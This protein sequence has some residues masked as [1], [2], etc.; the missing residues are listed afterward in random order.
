MIVTV[1]RGFSDDPEDLSIYTGQK[2]SH[3]AKIG[4]KILV[5][6]RNGL[7]LVSKL[8][9][10]PLSK[11]VSVCEDRTK[12][13]VIFQRRDA[14]GKIYYGIRPIGEEKV[15]R[16][17]SFSRDGAQHLLFTIDKKTVAAAK[18]CDEPCLYKLYLKDEDAELS[19]IFLPFVLYYI[20]RS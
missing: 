11:K 18:S 16:V 8:K 19:S 17:Q 1:R 15:F 9:K 20:S 14:H 4:K 10:S 2:I 5:F 3:F 12:T 13:A 6:D 7:V